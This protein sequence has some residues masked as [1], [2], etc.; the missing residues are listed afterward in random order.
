M[1]GGP[2]REIGGVCRE[3][4]VGELIELA[5]HLD[6]EAEIPIGPNTAECRSAFEERAVEPLRQQDAGRRESGRSCADNGNPFN[7]GES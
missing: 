6:A 1:K 3:R 2:G 4:P 7:R 5:L